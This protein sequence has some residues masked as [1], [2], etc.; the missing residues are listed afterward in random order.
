MIEEPSLMNLA[1]LSVPAQIREVLLQRIGCGELAPG[2]RIVEGRLT[3]EFAVSAIPVR[4][5]IRELVA[6][7]V[8]D[9]AAHKG[10]WVREV[11]VTET[12]EAFQVRA[13]LE[14]LAAMTAA[15]ALR[16]NCGELRRVCKAIVAAARRRDF[17]AYQRE[18]QA[19]HRA[20]VQASEN[21]VLLRVWESLAFEVR[22]RFAL[23]FLKTADFVA[24]ARE[25]ES[26]VDAL[27]AGDAQRASQS[28]HSHSGHLVEYLRNEAAEREQLADK[29]TTKK[30]TPS[31]SRG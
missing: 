1:R 11:S 7:G 28:L 30:T 19:F 25:H 24:I 9:S 20:I 17:D 16:G 14:S 15:D 27:D 10:A 22:T 26:I 21:G 3:E 12:I 2:E 5:A 8:L 4:E 13:A 31:P 18:N 29:P 6:K 23:E